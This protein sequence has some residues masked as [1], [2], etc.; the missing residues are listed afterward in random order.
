MSFYSLQFLV[1]NQATSVVETCVHAMEATSLQK[2]FKTGFYLF[3]IC[4]Y[5]LY[6][7]VNR[8]KAKQTPIIEEGEV[9]QGA[10]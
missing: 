5:F 1:G 2:I 3:C 10:Y 9:F 6:D 4:I 7:T 8:T